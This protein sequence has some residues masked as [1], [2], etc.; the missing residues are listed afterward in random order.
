M[1]NVSIWR[2][3]IAQPQMAP[4]MPSAGAGGAAMVNA[5]LGASCAK[6][7]RIKAPPGY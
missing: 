7:L 4:V 6:K 2:Y 3:N 1:P 5:R